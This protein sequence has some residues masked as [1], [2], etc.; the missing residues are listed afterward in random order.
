MAVSSNYLFDNLIQKIGYVK[1][2]NQGIKERMYFAHSLNI[3]N[4]LLKYISPAE[5]GHIGSGI[6]ITPNA[7]IVFDDNYANTTGSLLEFHELF[8][9]KIEQ[10]TISYAKLNQGG[11]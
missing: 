6:I 4:I 2:L 10:N 1:L 3:Q 8:E 11:K 7:N 5:N 9:K